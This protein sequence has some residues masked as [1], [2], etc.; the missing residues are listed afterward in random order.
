MR[1]ALRPGALGT[2]QSLFLHPDINP[3]EMSIKTPL[4]MKNA[5]IPPDKK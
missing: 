5:T 4:Q 3:L 1:Q 2:L